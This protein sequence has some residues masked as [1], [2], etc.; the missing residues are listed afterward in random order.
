MACVPATQG[1]LAAPA[2]VARRFRKDKIVISIVNGMSP[3]A[4]MVVARAMARV[5]V[6][7]GGR[8]L[9]VGNVILD[10][11]GRTVRHY[12]PHKT[13]VWAEGIATWTAIAIA[14]NP[15]QGV[16]AENV[17]PETS[18]PFVMRDVAQ[19]NTAI[20][21]EGAS[22]RPAYANV[23][24]VQVVQ[25][26]KTASRAASVL[27]ATKFATGRKP[28]AAPVVA[29]VLELVAV[30]TL[31]PGQRVASARMELKEK[32]VTSSATMPRRVVDEVTAMG[33][34]NVAAVK[35]GQ[36]SVAPIVLWAGTGTCVRYLA[37]RQ[38]HAMIGEHVQGRGRA[39]VETALRGTIVTSAI[40]FGMDLNAMSSAMQKHVG[41]TVVAPKMESANAPKVFPAQNARRVWLM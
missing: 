3:V 12:A 38:I 1:W 11:V 9:L 23:C 21:L 10:S 7:L 14:M 2:K 5:R 40:S 6:I 34:H 13:R 8:V 29:T 36:E 31:T 19:R 18:V 27:D 35:D 17:L 30:T 20:R 28:V 26:V 4:S 24:W 16:T 33:M 39:I 25:T 15:S 37:L 32:I 41:K 22:G